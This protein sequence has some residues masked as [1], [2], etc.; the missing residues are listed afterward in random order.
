MKKS[1]VVVLVVGIVC[2]V[3]A[4]LGGLMVLGAM[5]SS[6]TS[7]QPE[8][9]ECNTTDATIVHA[10]SGDGKIRL[11][12]TG[13]FTVTSPFGM[14]NHPMLGITRLHAGVD[15]AMS[16][17]GGPVV[18]PMEGTVQ[19]VNPNVPG[20]GNF[21]VLSHGDG[22]T[23][24]YLH[25][26]SMSVSPGQKVKIGQEI[27]REGNTTGG[28]NISTGAHLH[29]EVIENGAATD[30]VPWL[31]QRGITLP[32]V[33]GSGSAGESTTSTASDTEGKSSSSSASG[34]KATQVKVGGFEL[35]KPSSPG[36][37]TPG[38][39]PLPI[40]AAHMKAFKSAEKKYGIPWQWLA[41]HS[42][43]ETHHWKIK[44][45]SSAGAMGPMQF[46]PPTWIDYGVDGDGDGKAEI[47]D[48]E[49]SI[50]SAANM[51]AKNGGTTSAEGVRSAIKRY[52]NADWYVSDILWISHQ[53]ADGK[54][55]VTSAGAA[56]GGEDCGKA[57]VV[58]AAVTSDCPSTDSPAEKGLT[59]AALDVLRCGAEAE[60]AVTTMYGVGERP[61]ADDHPAGRAVDFMIPD[62]TSTQGNAQGWKLAKWMR[63]NAEQLDIEY[64]IFD[65]KI[66]HRSRDAQGW[67]PMED[68]GSRTANH[69]DHVHVSVA[70]SASGSG[71]K[72]PGATAQGDVPSSRG[73][74]NES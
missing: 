67:R 5:L 35:P 26:A 72:P 73:G 54:V 61:I 33:G 63:A 28:T 19:S 48:V 7:A 69:E 74:S 12:L 3:G 39:K 43:E 68:R 62:Y 8:Y 41:G 23:T 50:H 14:R 56:G 21:I 70:S 20:A 27:G 42:M 25:L 57:G 58:Q 17:T 45:V 10:G 2:L 51:L 30:P 11:P 55:S 9:E 37:H 71:P 52:N 40:P 60:P 18:A 47:L 38:T 64:V 65:Q 49:D 36:R 1:V 32:A 29:F 34:G 13:K 31:K 15:L 6:T 4:P 16:P 66:W 53:Y 22:L 24:R 59:P 46:T 44:A